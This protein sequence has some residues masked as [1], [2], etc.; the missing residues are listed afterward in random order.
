M[1]LPS[2][3][4]LVKNR[5]VDT[6]E[7][8]LAVREALR[9]DFTLDADKIMGTCGLKAIPVPED[10][11]NNCV[12][13]RHE[14]EYFDTG[15]PYVATVMRIDGGSWFIGCWGDTLARLDRSKHE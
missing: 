11:Y 3:K 9:Q 4:N 14:I 2:I 15:D 13:P 10:A 12:T 7:E 8:A 6:R 5:L 1:R